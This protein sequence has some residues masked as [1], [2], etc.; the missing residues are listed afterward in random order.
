LIES[1]S[2]PAR[3]T[4]ESNSLPSEQPSATAKPRCRVLGRIV[5]ERKQP[6]ANAQVFLSP[7]D[8]KWSDT[9]KLPTVDVNGRSR[10]RL[11]ATTGEDGRFALDAPVPT[12]DSVALEV[13][14]PLYFSRAFRDYGRTEYTTTKGFVA[15]DNYVGDIEVLACGAVAGRVVS[16]TGAPLDNALVAAGGFK[17]RDGSTVRT[18]ATGAFLAGHVAEGEIALHVELDGRLSQR[19][20]HVSVQRGVTTRIADVVLARSPEIA[21]IVVDTSGAPVPSVLVWGWPIGGSRGAGAKT[22]TDGTFVIAL[23]EERPYSFE[24]K[25]DVFE[26]WGI[27]QRGKPE[28]TFEPGRRDVR[29]VLQRATQTTFRVI[30]ARTHEP[31][32]TFGIRV[33]AKPAKGP[34]KGDGG[35]EIECSS[36][37]LGE[38]TLAAKPATSMVIV[39]APGHADLETEVRR[40]AGSDS[41]QTLALVPAGSIVGRLVMSGAPVAGGSI[42]MQRE[43]LDD[44]GRPAPLE[45]SA[46][47]NAHTDVGSYPGRGRRVRAKDDGTFTLA[48][49]AAGTYQLQIEA[50]GAGALLVRGVK[51]SEGDALQLGDIQLARAAIVRGRLI[52]PAGDSPTSYSVFMD[53]RRERSVDITAQDGSFEF[54]GLEAGPHTITWGRERKLLRAS[55]DPHLQR[56]DLAAG[57]ERN[58]VLD[59][60]RSDKCAV[61]TQVLRNGAPAAG[62][63]VMAQWKDRRTSLGRTGDDGKCTGEVEGDLVFDLV[64]VSPDNREIGDGGRGLH[65]VPGGRMELTIRISTGSVLLELPPDLVAPQEGFVSFALQSDD[66]KVRASL[67]FTP[68]T[69]VANGNERWSGSTIRFTDVQVGTSQCTVSFFRLEAPTGERNTQKTT[70]VRPAFTQ[71]VTIEEGRET[72]ILV[73]P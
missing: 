27:G 62:L 70:P 7:G 55:D 20:E 64:A 66:K 1:A 50:T 56:L 18:D 15:G 5:D 46:V 33:D 68:G 21:G 11:A 63:E 38:V 31:I 39:T 36:H 30:D 47:A 54:V 24:I 4:A 61:T 23:P 45:K 41:V 13:D 22:Q 48:D 37:P 72:K 60:S 3:I 35:K 51:V 14:P 73:P 16:D 25:S 12:C 17:R 49:L 67:A 2:S 43:W 57:E 58:V 59:A 65:A 32:E 28:T 10:E 53:S 9:A 19:I 8:G 71:T 69:R 52:A 6:V 34:F 26:P 44:L 40:D 29:I 42:T